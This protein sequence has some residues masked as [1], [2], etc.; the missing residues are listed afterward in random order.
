MFWDFLLIPE[1]VESVKAVF[2]NLSGVSGQSE[3]ENYWVTRDG[4]RRFIRWTNSSVLDKNG[5]VELVI[6]TGIDITERK[7]AEIEL[8]RYK[9]DLERLV[10]ERTAALRASE[11]LLMKANEMKI[12]G[13]L[14]SGV[15]HEV[16]N[17]LNGIIAIMGALSKEL[18]D[19]EHFQPYVHHM[20]TQVTR[21][22]V[23]MEDLLKLG[24]PIQKEKMTDVS[25]VKLVTDAV[26]AW[27]DGLQAQRD[28]RL[29]P[30]ADGVLTVRAEPARMEQMVVNLL[31][32]AHQ[33]T[34]AGKEIEVSIRHAGEGR[35]LF[36]VR[37]NGPG[38]P[39]DVMPRI[40]EPFFT[41]RKGG[42]GLGLSIVR[43]IVE[44]HGGSISAFNNEGSSGTTFEVKL[45][46]AK[47][48]DVG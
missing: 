26:A 10:M 6:G 23:L 27:K 18:S 8:E 33:H 5:K 24:R 11:D 7:Q 35:V 31:D 48:R 15:A 1:E 3:Y 37:D 38:I 28:V 39:K 36:S 9:T 25:F 32:N 16:R 29:D 43:H 4:A 12:L 40:F 42:T 46:L 45:P 17:P 22:T 19:S 41:T 20:R 34:P 21:L 13:Q 30:V 14:T 2:G 44:S 47:A